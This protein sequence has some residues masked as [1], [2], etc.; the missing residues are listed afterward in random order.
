MPFLI[1]RNL[2]NKKDMDHIL[3]VTQTSN[4][5]FRFEIIKDGTSSRTAHSLS[6]NGV[7]RGWGNDF[8]VFDKDGVIRTVDARGKV[9][10]SSMK[11][12][13]PKTE[14][15]SGVG[16]DQFSILTRSKTIKVFDKKCKR[17]K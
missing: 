7:I 6:V 16:G 3:S 8:A 12:Y 13:D 14:Q 2:L 10:C 4:H 11:C 1:L 9:I 17:I 15:F 5:L